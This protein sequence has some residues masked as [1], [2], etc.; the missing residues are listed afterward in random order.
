MAMRETKVHI[1][2][3]EISKKLS[4]HKRILIIGPLEVPKNLLLKIAGTLIPTAIIL[5]DG[6]QKHKKKLTDYLKKHSETCCLFIG[7]GDS[8]KQ[9]PAYLLPIEKDYSDL[10]FAL[11]CL[12]KNKKLKREIEIV[13][14]SPLKELRPDHFLINLGECENFVM[15]NKTPVIIHRNDLTSGKFIICPSGKNQFDARS[16]FSLMSLRKNK[17]KLGG[18]AQY[19]LKTWT[20]LK[21]LSSFGLSN[22]GSGTVKI[23]STA[24]LIIFME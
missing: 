11:K 5:I 6:G 22:V 20:A 10:S 23:E 9:L 18:K 12:Q 14:I 7:D 4:S 16:L 24:P 17:I 3:K 15:K 2:E 8:G 1:L 19:T 21:V 13:G